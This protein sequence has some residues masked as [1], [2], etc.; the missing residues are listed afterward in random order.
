[1]HSTIIFVVDNDRI[2]QEA[3]KAI[4]SSSNI[5]LRFYSSSMEILPL[6]TRE[7]PALIFLNLE[8]PD[9]NDFIMF[10]LL[11]KAES[12]SIPIHITYSDSSENDLG[13]Y[14]KLKYK[15]AGYYK[16]PLSD[17]IFNSIC[18]GFLE[19]GALDS[20]DDHDTLSED[21]FLDMDS[22]DDEP[23]IQMDELDEID[24][25]EFSDENI[26]KLIKGDSIPIEFDP[27][28]IDLPPYTKRV[29]S[30][31]NEIV[32]ISP[33]SS[34]ETKDELIINI[35]NAVAPKAPNM[36]DSREIKARKIDRELEAQVI[37]LENQNEFLRTENKK[38]T[39][40]QKDLIEQQKKLEVNIQYLTS[41]LES[42]N[43]AYQELL[44]KNESDKEILT[45]K[46][47]VLEKHT[48]QLEDHKSDLTRKLRDLEL[49]LDKLSD[50]KSDIQKQSEELYN[51]LTDKERESVARNHK[52]EVELKKKLDEVLQEAEERWLNEYK[53]KENRISHDFQQLQNEKKEIELDLLNKLEDLSNSNNQLEAE[54][55]ELKKREENLNRAVSAL[56][57]EKVTIS[58]KLSLAQDQL[59][60][61]E[62]EF[63]RK[64]AQ[65]RK[66]LEDFANELTETRNRRD[67]YKKRIEEMTQ[68]LQKALSI[69]ENQSEN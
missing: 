4:C 58:E 52:F 39:S 47:E 7:K 48:E 18:A 15:A 30:D 68:L 25:D 3:I 66:T 27:S 40:S 46:V 42:K 14:Q 61:T 65:Y 37:S 51:R 2:F 8:V 43:L 17:E 28:P 21:H 6:I 49:Q 20:R 56:A 36:E 67:F 44:K 19:S 9:V 29:D 50:E 10:D 33:L 12:A 63:E 13:K 23:E 55:Q 45:R 38:L 35:E 59:Q 62:S 57:E 54:K 5:D 24:D 1:M 16:K 34:S 22:L 31:T 69:A 32:K 64:E 11:K 60:Q 41:D 26:D 53:Q